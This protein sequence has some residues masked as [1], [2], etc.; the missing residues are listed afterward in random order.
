MSRQDKLVSGA[1][2][3]LAA[4]AFGV[5]APAEAAGTPVAREAAAQPPTVVA[6]NWSLSG[7]VARVTC[8]AGTQLVGGGQDARLETTL[9]GILTDGVEANAPDPDYPNSWKV[10]AHH[11]QA[12][13]FA[14]CTADA[15]TPTVVASDWSAKGAVARATCPAGTQLV[16]GGQDA[17]LETTLAGNVTDDV[18]AN[19]PDPEYPNT[20]KV[21]LHYGQARAFA[22]C[23]ADAPTPTVV[24][25]DWSLPGEVARVTCPAGTQLVGGGQDARLETN[26]FTGVLVDG[27]EANAPDPDYPNS[28]KVQAHYGQARAFAMCTADAPT[29][30]VVASDWSVRGAV[31]RATCPAGTQLVGGGQDARL[32]TVTGNVTDSVEANAPDPEYPNTWKVQLHSGQAR[33]FAMCTP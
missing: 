30:T 19:A 16:G 10:Q 3:A 6:S 17:R 9:T 8:P 2:C 7:E 1:V 20:W 13:A 5:A 23:T 21:Q 4:T 25:S 14:M 15:P 32:D 18:E 11:G 27:V 28:W 24:A 26:P 31:A 22:M 33:A 12:R 29:P